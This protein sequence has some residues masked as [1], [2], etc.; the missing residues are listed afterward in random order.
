MQL[1]PGGS[2]MAWARSCKKSRLSNLNGWRVKK[3]GKGSQ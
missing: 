1:A 2:F 3:Y